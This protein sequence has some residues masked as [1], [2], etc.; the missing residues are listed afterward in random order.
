MKIFF[1]SILRAALPVGCLLVAFALL[2]GCN[3]N[4][5][6]EAMLPPA[7]TA[8]YAGATVNPP[9]PNHRSHRRSSRVQQASRNPPPQGPVAIN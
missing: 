8:S 7:H 3:R 2:T 1:P 9:I 4:R 6:V 5:G